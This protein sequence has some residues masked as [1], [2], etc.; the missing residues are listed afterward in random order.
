MSERPLISRRTVL[1]LPLI[2]ALLFLGK[3]SDTSAEK[4]RADLKLN[5]KLFYV[6]IE[7]L[8]SFNAFCCFPS[9]WRE[10]TPTGKTGL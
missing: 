4:L 7:R 6:L 1:K 10:K 2:G 8:R 3:E 9:W 5:T